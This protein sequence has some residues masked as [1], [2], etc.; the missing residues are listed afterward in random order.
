VSAVALR[1]PWPFRLTLVLA[2][3]LTL[4]ASDVAAQEA[5]VRAKALFDKA[6]VHFSL[7]EFDKALKFYGA[8]YRVK[9]MPEFLFNMGQCHRYL[10]NH[11]RAI[12]HYKQFMLKKPSSPQR[13]QVEQLVAE[14]EGKLRAERAASAGPGTGAPCAATS[15]LSR[16]WFWAG[17]GL[18]TALTLTSI[19]TGV[20]A[21]GQGPHEDTRALEI[22][23]WVTLG[24]A[25]V[26]AASTVG[27][28]WLSRSK[29]QKVD[30]SL[31]LVPL[32]AQRS[33]GVLLEGRF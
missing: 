25:V 11:E 6:E 2:L 7:R 15:C 26:A 4:F 1:A 10:G 20:V 18:T 3:A 22:T 14:S 29:P 12:F 31:R 32:V 27:L 19:T 30:G 9:P 23:S 13:P 8:A 28:F 24:G 21:S 17:V 5:N 16:G 33:G